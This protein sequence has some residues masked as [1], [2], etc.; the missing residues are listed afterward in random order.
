MKYILST[1]LALC[2]AF[3][4]QAQ[5]LTVKKSESAAAALSKIN[6]TRKPSEAMGYRI[7]IFFDNSQYAR[8]KA[9]KAKELFLTEFPS[10]PVYMVYESPYYKVSAGN[11]LTEEEAL[12]LFERIRR[13]FPDAF[14]MREKI[15]ISDFIIE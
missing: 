10:Q 11:C 6:Q 2:I 3:S 7:G 8:A 1:L 12:I 5:Q 14:V 15:K 13:T 9:T 4:S